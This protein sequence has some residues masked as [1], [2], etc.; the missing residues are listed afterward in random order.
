MDVPILFKTGQA[1]WL[2]LTDPSPSK[3]RVANNLPF[4][5]TS[6]RMRMA[7]RFLPARVSFN[8]ITCNDSLGSVAAVA[9]A[10]GMIERSELAIAV[11]TIFASQRQSR[12]SA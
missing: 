1:D 6:P 2:L 7:Y 11:A 9:L 3:S 8:S 5:V 10:E 12:L 4:S